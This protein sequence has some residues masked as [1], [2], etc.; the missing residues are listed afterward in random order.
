MTRIAF[1]WACFILSIDDSMDSILDWIR[2]RGVIFRATGEWSDIRIEA[3]GEYVSCVFYLL[4]R[5]AGWPLG[6]APR[7]VRELVY[8]ALN[9]TAKTVERRLPRTS[10]YRA[11]AP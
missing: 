10:G 6:G 3:N 4:C 2:R 5:L 8:V 7:R 11:P 1:S 9:C